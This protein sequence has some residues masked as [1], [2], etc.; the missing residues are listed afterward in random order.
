[1]PGAIYSPDTLARMVGSRVRLRYKIGGVE[2][3]R[4]V[5][6]E[7]GSGSGARACGHFR[8][9]KQT[10]V[11]MPRTYHESRA[12]GEARDRGE[13][14]KH[15]ITGVPYG[16]KIPLVVVVPLRRITGIEVLGGVAR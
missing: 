15:S 16:E 6:V 5:V 14:P 3:N 2:F 11:C 12:A 1:M 13:S 9:E 8:A 7:G 4:V 10:I